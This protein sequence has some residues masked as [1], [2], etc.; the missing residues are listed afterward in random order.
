MVV[1]ADAKLLFIDTSP[2]W[3]EK[4]ISTVKRRGILVADATHNKEYDLRKPEDE[5]TFRALRKQ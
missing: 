4:F 2:M 5:E 3:M 1:V